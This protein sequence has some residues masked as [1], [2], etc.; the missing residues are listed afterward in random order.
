VEALGA[1]GFCAALFL[2]LSDRHMIDREPIPNCAVVLELTEGR[3]MSAVS[4][5][6]SA[7]LL[8]SPGPKSDE[9]A[10][11]ERA[12]WQGT[13]RVVQMDIT[14]GDRTSRLK[15]SEGEEAYL[16]I[17]GDCLE[18]TGLNFPYHAATITFD[19][20]REPKRITLALTDGDK[21]GP[22]V[23]GTYTHQS[24]GIELELP[25]WPRE[26]NETV[27]L[28]LSLKRVKE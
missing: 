27:N 2:F 8:S 24:D 11:A 1:I 10:K 26:K 28:R 15:F 23:E 19:L 25:K 5:F 9:P 4:V 14:I 16:R 18:M 20:T 6:I 17:K 12:K 22:V 21:K 3:G 7:F 13:W